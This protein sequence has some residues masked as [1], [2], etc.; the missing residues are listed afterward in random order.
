VEKKKIKVNQIGKNPE[1]PLGNLSPDTL[2]PLPSFHCTSK[3]GPFINPPTDEQRKKHEYSLDGVSAIGL[4]RLANKEEEEKLVQRF[5]GGLRKLL[6]WTDNWTFY[7]PLVLSL[8]S[9]AKC[10]L[11]SEACPIYVASG[12]QEIYRPTFRAEVLKRVIKK[13]LKRGGKAFAKVTGEDLD[14]N[15]TVIARLAELAY[16]CTLCRR[17]AQV[18]P[19]G[20]DNALVSREIRK[21]FSQEMGIA[22]QEIHA[23]GTVQ[24]LKVGSTTGITPP[25]LHDIVVFLEEE[26]KEKTGK[27]VKIPVDKKGA[28]VL[29]LHN[30]GEFISWPENIEAF[31]ILF[32]AANISWTLSSELGGY[33]A[34]NYGV[35]YDDIQLARIA[36]KHAQV[37]KDLNVKK[38]NV[39]ECGHAHKAFIV[40]ADRVLT[41][42]LNIPRE[43]ALPLLEHLVCRDKIRTDP[44]KN[45]FPVTLHDPC[46]IV[47]IMGI[48]EPQRRILRKICPQFREME[49]HGVDNYCCGGGSGFAIMNSRNFKDWKVLVSG[50]MKTKQ[51]LEAFQDVPNPEIKKYVCAPCSN[52]KG[53]IRDLLNYYNIGEK[54]NIHYGGLVELIVNA[55]VDI[56]KPFIDWEWR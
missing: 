32:N 19:M 27:E 43:S 8:D 54:Y 29:L 26:I 28:D 35:W 50:R 56:E 6:S 11:C 16:R 31:A 38:I 40:V 4:A 7:Q 21:L 5:L 33:D 23:Q 3:N 18:C 15:W 46:N 44:G 53:Q 39:G 30:A 36:V 1:E 52:C 25:A 49:P 51:I 12:R 41:G 9:C 48:T 37:A 20:V 2:V 14:L 42:D 47:R 55:M 45:N 13:Y 22:P 17:C 34:V 24:Q 10:Q